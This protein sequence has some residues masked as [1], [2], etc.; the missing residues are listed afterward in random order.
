MS[1]KT[2]LVQRH[3][4]PGTTLTD[5]ALEGIKDQLL[6]RDT[7]T[8][9][10]AEGVQHEASV[11]N[12][13]VTDIGV[14]VTFQVPRSF[15]LDKEMISYPVSMGSKPCPGCTGCTCGRDNE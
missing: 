10:D 2:T 13:A 7:I 11:V 15:V 8:I 12:A 9:T 14:E 4:R 1:Y 5:D 6:D 3:P